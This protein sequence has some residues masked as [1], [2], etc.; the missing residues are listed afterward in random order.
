MEIWSAAAVALAL[1]ADGLAVGA[2]YGLRRIQVPARSLLVIGV[3]SAA[4]FAAAMTAGAA[5]AGAGVWRA[6]NV[7]GAAVFVALGAWNMAKGW[8][9]SRDEA[10]TL[11]C[12]RLPGP[13]I[14][15]QVLKEPGRADVDG[16]GAIDA[17]EAV[18]LGVALGL[19]ALA[20]GL[21]AAFTGFG[22]YAVAL[23]AAAQV[24][25][26]WVGLHL[27]RRWGAGW[28]GGK[29]SYAPGAILILIGLLQL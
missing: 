26:T 3:C 15:I 6:P 13:G 14:V 4:C 11:L 7:A 16:S 17:G 12:I 27:G 28:L 9:E 19:D 20:A 29:G 10:A 8:A 22:A 25:L 5:L 24:L 21:G 2:A 18:V 1:G 23:V